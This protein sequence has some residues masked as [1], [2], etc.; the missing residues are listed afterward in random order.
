MQPTHLRTGFAQQLLSQ[1]SHA[2]KW[3]GAPFAELLLSDVLHP[4]FTA[5][6]AAF[7]M[8]VFPNAL[9]LEPEIEAAAA[10]V[11]E[12]ELG[13]YFGSLFSCLC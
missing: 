9:A 8:I 1:P 12:V 6:A 2:L 7:K 11:G 4:N 5:A 10:G 13:G 3:V